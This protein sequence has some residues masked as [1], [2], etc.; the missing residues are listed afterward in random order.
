MPLLQIA[1]IR[2]S[3]TNWAVISAFMAHSTTRRRR[4]M[5][6]AT[7]SQRSAAAD[8]GEVGNPLLVRSRAPRARRSMTLSDTAARPP[9]SFGNPRRPGRARSPFSRISR[10]IGCSPQERPFA[11]TSCQISAVVALEAA[12]DHA[13]QHLVLSGRGAGDAVEPGLWS[14]FHPTDCCS[15]SLKC[16]LRNKI[17]GCKTRRLRFRTKLG[18]ESYATSNCNILKEP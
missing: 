5:T 7:Q 4:L 11:K 17:G 13:Q 16:R 3:M 14:A 9:V 10:S 15:F 6:V 18:F 12:V 1:M 2:A 8:V